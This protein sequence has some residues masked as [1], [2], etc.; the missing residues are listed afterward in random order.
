MGTHIG[1]KNI[2]IYISS[3]KPVSFLSSF[4]IVLVLSLDFTHPSKDAALDGWLHQ[5]REHHVELLG[6]LVV[7]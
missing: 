7:R 6:V 2:Y 4:L 3:L 1:E 5:R